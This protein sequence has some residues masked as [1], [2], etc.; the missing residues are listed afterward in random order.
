MKYANCET[1]RPMLDVQVMQVVVT[2]LTLRGEG[3]NGDPMRRVTE[4]WDMRGNK[5]A[6][7]DPELVNGGCQ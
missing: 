5:I 2:R 1:V 4:V 3:V 7:S 6:E